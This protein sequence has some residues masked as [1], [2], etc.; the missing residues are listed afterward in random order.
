M[1]LLFISSQG[2]S[3][4]PGMPGTPGVK[5]DVVRI[6]DEIHAS[7]NNQY[8]ISFTQGTVMKI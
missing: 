4:I 7:L 2:D 5:G 6:T 3:G 1:I 8:F